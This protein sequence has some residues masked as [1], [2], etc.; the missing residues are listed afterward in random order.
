MTHQ[1]IQEELSAL[2]QLDVD[3]VVAYDRAIS[4]IGQGEVAAQLGT[5]RLDHQRHVLELSQAMLDLGLPMPAAQPDVKGALLGG[6]TGLRARLGTE[7]ALVAMRSNEQLTTSS[8]ARALAKPFPEAILEAVRRGAADEQRH[9]AW[10]ERAIDGRI[11][12]GAGA[13]P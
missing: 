4:A 2:V 3:A 10:I 11:W 9:L 5:F 13:A 7:Q 8:Y 6:L 1:E 12:E